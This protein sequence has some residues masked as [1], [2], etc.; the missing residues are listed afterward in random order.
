MKFFFPFHQSFLPIDSWT[1]HSCIIWNI[2]GAVDS[3]SKEKSLITLA[4]QLHVHSLHPVIS[5]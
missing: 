3:N 4:A 5:L 1:K 2:V